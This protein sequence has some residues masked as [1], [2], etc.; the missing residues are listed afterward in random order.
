[1]I[2]RRE[3][4]KAIDTNIDDKVKIGWMLDK[5]MAFEKNGQSLP[6]KSKS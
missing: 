2:V 5:V 4:E 3:P 6:Y 1:M